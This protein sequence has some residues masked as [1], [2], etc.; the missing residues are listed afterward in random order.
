MTKTAEM[1]SKHNNP[2]MWIFI[3]AVIAET[4]RVMLAVECLFW[5]GP[6]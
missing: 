2:M 5:M 6:H 4:G 1:V 3:G